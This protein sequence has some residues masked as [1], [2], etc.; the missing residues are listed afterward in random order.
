MDKILYCAGPFSTYNAKWV[1]TPEPDEVMFRKNKEVIELCNKHN[2]KLHIKVHPSDEKAN[3]AHFKYLTK[4]YPQVKVVGGY[5]KW[6]N[7]A[8]R[9][10]PRYQLVVLDILRTALL[11]IMARSTVPC[12]IYTERKDCI[13]KYKLEGL[14]KIFHMVYN[15]KELDKLL[16]KFSFG[17]LFQ[18]E[19]E[20]LMKKWF[21][22]RETIENWYKVGRYNFI[23]RRKFRQEWKSD[24][25]AYVT[26]DKLWKRI[27]RATTPPIPIIK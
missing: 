1:Y 18:P 17:E 10:I 23:L 9:M 8:Q 21:T 11:P 7:T 4:N 26:M 6:L 3:L 22:K 12:I 13:K 2:L 25:Q 20:Q 19:E 15:R 24:G 16:V 14:S 27:E 5:W